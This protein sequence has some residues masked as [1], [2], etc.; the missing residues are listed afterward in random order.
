[1]GQFTENSVG[2]DDGNE[3]DENDFFYC[4]LLP[5]ANL[6]FAWP[7]S[8]ATRS[9]HPL[10]QTSAGIAALEL[11]GRTRLNAQPGAKR[12]TEV[13]A[14]VSA[15]ARGRCGCLGPAI[16]P[17]PYDPPPAGPGNREGTA[18]EAIR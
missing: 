6:R 5:L 14:D 1:M 4:L 10:L 9:T 18:I 15:C 12:Q 2:R 3:D 11:P 17:A 13:G 16:G 7:S 8:C